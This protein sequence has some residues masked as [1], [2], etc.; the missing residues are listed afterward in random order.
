MARSMA[1]RSG[2]FRI[3][4]IHGRC[5]RSASRGRSMMLRPPTAMPSR[6]TRWICG[7][8]LLPSSIADT[9]S[10]ARHP[11]L[12]VLP[13]SIP[14][15][16]VPEHTTP[17]RD[18]LAPRRRGNGASSKPMARRVRGLQGSLRMPARARVCDCGHYSCDGRVDECAAEC[19]RHRSTVARWHRWVQK[20]GSTPEDGPKSQRSTLLHRGVRIS[21]DSSSEIR[22]L[23]ASRY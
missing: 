5:R 18:T 7:R 12:L 14:S 15:N 8:Y 11:S 9:A 21:A 2:A 17:A 20:S 22:C 1:A 10:V 6:R 3:T 13:H 19:R 23:G 4:A 16:R